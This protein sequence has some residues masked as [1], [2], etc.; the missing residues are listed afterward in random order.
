MTYYQNRIN[1][2]VYHVLSDGTGA[3]QFLRTMVLNYL[4]VRYRDALGQMPLSL[5]YDASGTQKS[6]DSFQKYYSGDK[7]KKKRR[8][9]IAYRLKG[10]K[11]PENRIR[12]IE[13]ILPVK[14]LLAKAHDYGTC[15][16]Y[17][18]CRP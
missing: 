14:N 3:L 15:L 16:L 6:D 18:S 9:P 17:T 4:S 11:T 8:A 7:K 10:A 12:V 13:G 5:D 1:L 2:E